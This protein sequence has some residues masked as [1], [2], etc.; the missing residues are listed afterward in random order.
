MTSTFNCLQEP[1]MG[2]VSI[3]L[4]SI[5]DFGLCRRPSKRSISASI[6]TSIST[7]LCIYV[8]VC[9]CTCIYICLDIYVYYFFMYICI[10][11]Y[12]AVYVHKQY[13]YAYQNLYVFI[14]VPFFHSHR[15]ALCTC[16]ASTRL[17]RRWRPSEDRLWPTPACWEAVHLKIRST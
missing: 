14:K 12:L 17:W 11:M 1:P 10:Y 3:L 6:S 16:R 7:Y 13:V 4:H 15:T 2:L 8:Y 9:I 5:P